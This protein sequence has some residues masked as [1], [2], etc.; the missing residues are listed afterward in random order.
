LLNKDDVELAVEFF[1]MKLPVAEITISNIIPLLEAEQ[2]YG[3]NFAVCFIG[4]N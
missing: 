3:R 2:I 4:Q 1:F